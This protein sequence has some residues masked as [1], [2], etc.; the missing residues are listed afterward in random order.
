MKVTVSVTRTDVYSKEV[1]IEV[2]DDYPIEA[3]EGKVQAMLDK[4]G[5]DAVCGDD[6]GEYCECSSEVDG[7]VCPKC[8]CRYHPNKTNCQCRRIAEQGELS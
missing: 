4:G 5:W 1:E 3:V 6:E 8:D 2:P 7:I